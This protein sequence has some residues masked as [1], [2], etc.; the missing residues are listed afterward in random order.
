MCGR[1]T[2]GSSRRR[3]GRRASRRQA[4]DRLVELLGR[5]AAEHRASDRRVGPERRRAGRSRRPGAAC[6]PRRGRSC[7]GSRCRRPSA[8]RR[9]AGSRP[10]AAAARRRRR[11]TAL[12]MLDQ[13]VEPGLR[14]GHGE[15][16]VRLARAGDRVAAQPVGVDREADLGE[17]SR[18]DVEVGVGDA[19][20]H[21]VLLA[22][23]ADVAAVLVRQVGDGEHLVAGDQAEVDRHADRARARACSGCT[24]M[25]S[26]RVVV[27]R[28]QREVGER[29][30]EP[31]L[32][33]LAH[34]FRAV[35]VDH[36][37]DAGLDARDAVAQVFL[38]CVEQRPQ[39][40][41]RLVLADE[42]AEVAG[43]ARHRREAAA[44]EHREARARP[45]G[46]RRR[47]RCS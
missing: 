22:G 47:A 13:G 41:E 30:A 40:G 4:L 38:P 9:R 26:A 11:R 16:A 45:R 5:H 24:P 19:R 20:E 43:D 31:P 44:D 3:R 23:D 1:R 15:V 35:V 27:E 37:L 25:W 18:D 34:A 6:P 21:E 28:R 14:L 46:S 2:T 7:P 12:E 42:D 39:H 36:E 8:G 29:V 10:G 33:L 17:P 32:D